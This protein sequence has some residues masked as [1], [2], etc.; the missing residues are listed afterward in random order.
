MVKVLTVMSDAAF[1]TTLQERFSQR[2]G[3]ELSLQHAQGALYALTMLERDTPHLII[4][5]KDLG[6]M[7]GLDFYE[8]VR[9]DTSAKDV[10]FI[11][12][13]PD[14]KQL[15]SSH[16]NKFL[17]ERAHPA[18]ILRAA[19]ELLIANGHI[20]EDRQVPRHRLRSTL[21]R[22]DAKVSGTLEVFTLFDLVVSLTQKENSGRLYVLLGD[23]ETVM[24]F[25]KGRFVHA[26]YEA[27]IG[28]DAV[29][30]IF[31]EADKYKDA[32]FFFEPSNVPLPQGSSTI[33]TTVQELLLKVAVELDH[34][35]ESALHP[36]KR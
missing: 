36:L 8:I 7:S 35:R 10:A 17:E 31:A 24:F 11:L 13:D 4:S 26:E 34:E 2:F 5:G 32:E 9:D 33:H 20:R 1:A 19:F 25:E 22:N 14:A 18:D 29:V 23:T 12:L 27:I 21:H 6:D 15:A 16:L 3:D 28:E 30:R